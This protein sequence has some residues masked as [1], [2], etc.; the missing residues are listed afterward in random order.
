MRKK[1]KLLGLTAV[2]VL[3]ISMMLSGCSGNGN[4]NEAGNT[5][6]AKNGSNVEAT[7]ENTAEPKLEPVDLN[8]Y[9]EADEQKDVGA[10]E[11]EL[12]KYL[13]DK[14]NAKIH[15][16]LISYANYK[17]KIDLNFASGEEMDIVSVTGWSTP[18]QTYVAKG[19]FLDI[20]ELLPKHA[21][22]LKELLSDKL[23]DAAL[24]NGKLY[25]VP[26]VKELGASFDATVRK[27]I[28]EQTGF[29][30]ASAKKPA[31]FAPYLEAA[32]K[33]NPQAGTIG[34]NPARFAGTGYYPI[35]GDNGALWIS[36]DDPTGK[37]VN[38][39]ETPEY[40]ESAKVVRDWWN[41]GYIFK[42]APIAGFDNNAALV[43][44]K[45]VLNF[46]YGKPYA[47]MQTKSGA[48]N[49][50]DFVNQPLIS[51]HFDTNDAIT[52]MQAISSTSKNP[53]RALMFLEL[54]NTDP[55]VSNLVN[56]G[57]EGEHYVKQADGTID[58][59]EGQTGQTTGYDLQRTWLVGNNFINLVRKGTP[60]DIWDK[61]KEFNDQAKPTATV[62]FVFNSEP[63]KTEVAAM[64]NIDIKYTG[65]MVAG[66]LDPETTIPKIIKE[67]KAA[68]IDKVLAEAQKQID[69]FLASKK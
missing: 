52:V 35:L 38:I 39:F 57:I 66:S 65:A 40:M 64:S 21:P 25:A 37:V 17:T 46:G 43:A 11:E 16:K 24:M 2:T 69:A 55:V 67:Y 23:Y 19:T 47:E 18:Y 59:P 5:G 42:D 48:Q 45:S 61:Y 56:F 33:L 63:V 53:E 62:G 31:D 32:K 58:Y 15:L 49:K 29:D 30:L 1:R 27:D 44:G 7:G 28:V 10:V 22:K 9:I 26:V 6:N 36:F 20:T 54:L 3:A 34:F 12:N 51:P 4:K 50:F 13:A 60:A 68:G 14:I 8:W 41:K